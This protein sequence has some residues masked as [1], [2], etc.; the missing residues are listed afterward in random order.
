MDDIFHDMDIFLNLYLFERIP[1]INIDV[2][3][4]S[5]FSIQCLKEF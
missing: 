3:R 5:L 1:Y 2:K 4:Q